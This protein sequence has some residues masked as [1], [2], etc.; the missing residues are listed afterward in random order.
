MT[1]AYSNISMTRE[2]SRF[3]GNEQC[4]KVWLYPILRHVSKGT[5]AAAHL[6]QL[7]PYARTGVV[8]PAGN[9]LNAGFLRAGHLLTGPKVAKNNHHIEHGT[10]TCGAENAG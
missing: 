8:R 10:F 6:S 2:A 3:D 7:L 9:R 4:F 1:R 5:A